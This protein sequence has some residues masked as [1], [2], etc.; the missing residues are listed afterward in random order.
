MAWGL[1]F[2]LNAPAA[3]NI[4]GVVTDSI[5]G[6]PVAGAQVTLSIAANA[7]GARTTESDGVFQ[8]LVNVPAGPAPQILSLQV[9]QPGYVNAT[10]NVVV[11]AGQADQLSYK[12]ALARVEA[13]NCAP[14][15]ERTVVVG[16]VRQPAAAAGDLALSRRVGEVLQ[17]DLLSEIQKTRLPPA[18]QPIVLACPDA[19]PRSLGEHADW[20]RAL[21]ADAFVVGMAESVNK[22]FKVDLQVTGRYADS[23]LPSL[24]ST[25]AMNLDLPPSAD[26]GRAALAPIML[27]LLKAYQKDGRYA[28]CVE[29]SVAAE[30]AL[31][32]QAELTELRKAC[33]SRLPNKA[34]Q[35]GG[36]K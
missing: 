2:S 30:N 4:S 18:R 15:W 31:G 8:L 11:S 35:S 1:L 12:V 33:Q 7:L 5:T 28:E 10:R 3:T 26:L 21:K 19:Q 14:N 22:R 9:A 23:P 34:L 13:R 16:F 6:Q 24:A 32:K 27:A 17:Y 25:P 29:F 36:V 20:A